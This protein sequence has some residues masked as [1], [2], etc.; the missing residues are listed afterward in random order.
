MAGRLL[1]RA[2]GNRADCAGHCLPAAAPVQA[3]MLRRPY[4]IPHDPKEERLAHLK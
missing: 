3:D 4:K 1:R 2:P